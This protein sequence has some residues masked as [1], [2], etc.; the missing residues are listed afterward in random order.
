MH[1]PRHQP[2]PKRTAGPYPSPA[3]LLSAC[4]PG[5]QVWDL[6]TRKLMR[7]VP[8]LDGTS[9]TF[10]SGGWPWCAGRRHL[11]AAV[12]SGWWQCVGIP[13]CILF[14]RFTQAS[15]AVRGTTAVSP[16]D[17]T[18]LLAASAAG[19]ARCCCCCPCPG[20]DVL[21]AWLRRPQDDSMAALLQPKR[22]RHALATSF[23]ILD[24]H[25]YSEISN[26]QV[27][28]CCFFGGVRV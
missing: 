10:S 19:A 27:S 18:P 20:G 23:A 5:R 4:L 26:V 6:R 3:P 11:C 25:S 7:S 14:L 24:A 22:R 8:L 21:C 16:A 17:C 28:V 12:D 1:T 9:I 13:T 15:T 2:F